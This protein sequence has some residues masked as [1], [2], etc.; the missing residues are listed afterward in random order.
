VAVAAVVAWEGEEER[1]AIEAMPLAKLSELFGSGLFAENG[2]SRITGDEFDQKS[3]ERDDGPN[4][5][6]QDY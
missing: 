5:E 2:D 4:N 6:E 1:R 3:Y